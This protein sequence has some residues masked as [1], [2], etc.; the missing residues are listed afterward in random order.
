MQWRRPCLFDADEGA[1]HLQKLNEKKWRSRSMPRESTGGWTYISVSYYKCDLLTSTL[2]RER[3]FINQLSLNFFSFPSAY[4]SLFL[5]IYQ[6]KLQHVCR[7]RHDD[8]AAFARSS[9]LSLEL[10]ACSELRAV[11]VRRPG[12]AHSWALA[13]VCSILII[14]RT[15]L[16]VIDD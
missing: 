1:G 16:H 7:Y 14:I 2:F 8:S 13:G 3:I 5:Y 9:D 15:W 11:H 4:T 12:T 6:R 10:L